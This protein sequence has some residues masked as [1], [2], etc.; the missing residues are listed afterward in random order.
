MIG[1]VFCLQ[2]DGPITGWGGE[3]GGLLSEG[4]YDRSRKSPSKQAIGSAEGGLHPGGQVI[5]SIF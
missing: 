1:S 2:V 4:A 5:G 3:G